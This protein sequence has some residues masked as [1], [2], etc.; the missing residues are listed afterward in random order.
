MTRRTGQL[1][2]SRPRLQVVLVAAVSLVATSACA[3]HIPHAAVH[4]GLN[5][6]ATDV[7]YGAGASAALPGV[8][9]LKLP[10][11]QPLTPSAQ[12]PS[13]YTPQPVPPPPSVLGCPAARSTTVDK[14]TVSRVSAAP[15]EAAY[16]FRSTQQVSSGTA[17]G[18]VVKLAE[19]RTVSNVVTAGNNIYFTVTAAYPAVGVVEA[20]NYQVVTSSDV[21]ADQEGDIP[22]GTLSGVNILSQSVSTTTKGKVTTSSVTWSPPLQVL[23]LPAATGT[24]WAVSSSDQKT[25]ESETYAA[26]VVG[27]AQVNACGALVQGYNVELTGKLITPG[28][29]YPVS[30]DETELIAPQ[31]GGLVLSDKASVTTQSSATASQTQVVTDTIN[32]TPKPPADGGSG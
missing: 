12:G 28:Q 24:N 2:G 10:P 23:K 11:P 29:S 13:A 3:Y 19:S 22:T 1:N 30:F 9:P 15:A 6:F 18:P 26:K 14:P 17:T 32:V 8:L 21:P 5:A 7:S 25:G 4:I 16:P 27:V 31:F 20:T